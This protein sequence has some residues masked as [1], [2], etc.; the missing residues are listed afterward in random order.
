MVCGSDHTAAVAIVVAAD[1][2]RTVGTDLLLASCVD[3]AVVQLATPPVTALDLDPREFGSH[4]ARLFVELVSRDQTPTEPVVEISPTRLRI[5][6]SSTGSRAETD[7][8]R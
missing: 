2:G 8:I 3:S 1:L 6:A 5:R 7:R 4:C